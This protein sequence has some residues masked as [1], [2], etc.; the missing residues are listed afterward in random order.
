MVNVNHIVSV[1]PDPEHPGHA[2]CTPDIVLAAIGDTV[3][4]LSLHG[5]NDGHVE[6]DKAVP[7]GKKPFREDDKWHGE[8][9]QA[10]TPLTV[11]EKGVFKYTVQVQVTPGDG[12][13]IKADPE[14]IG[15]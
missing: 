14:V 3:Q 12:E 15:K 2:I 10:S 1:D 11:V 5:P 6:L 4:W 9:G 8:K 13:P 7:P